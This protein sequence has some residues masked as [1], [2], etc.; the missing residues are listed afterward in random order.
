MAKKWDT[1]IHTSDKEGKTRKLNVSAVTDPRKVW[2]DAER[3]AVLMGGSLDYM[4]VKP[5]AEQAGEQKGGA[6]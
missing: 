2:D 3:M 6:A 4:V 1:E 5:V